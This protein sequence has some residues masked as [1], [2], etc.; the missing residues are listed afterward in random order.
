MEKPSIESVPAPKTPER[1]TEE[2]IKEID[3]I[4]DEHNSLRAK[5]EDLVADLPLDAQ[6]V[7]LEELARKRREIVAPKPYISDR[8]EIMEHM[9]PEAEAFFSE[10]VRSI[11]KNSREIDR[12]R[13][14][15]IMEY[16]VPGQ[17]EDQNV[18]YKIL[19]RSP[20]G[21]Q[22]DLM[23]EASYLADLHALSVEH[24]DLQIGVPKPFY[25]AT[26]TDARVIAMQK[27]PGESIENIISNSI[28]L[29]A[30]LDI[31][32]I[33]KELLEFV[34]R[35][36]EFGFYH[37]DLRRLG[38]IMIDLERKD[39]SK[40]LAYIIDTGNAK[41]MHARNAEGPAIDKSADHVM[42]QEVM[43]TLR[44]YKARVSQE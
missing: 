30:D 21:E 5:W 35:I 3:F 15:R 10:A 31:D 16:H 28:E 36:N 27:V 44:N 39:P 12:G 40:P 18:V 1:S 4:L 23:S 13:N 11:E 42:V 25:C 37:N 6:L 2:I 9:P 20:I 7:R 41:Y 38:N 24:S 43:K 29:P 22:N 32:H 26:L 34:E 17:E 8:L 19:I 14:G 33:E